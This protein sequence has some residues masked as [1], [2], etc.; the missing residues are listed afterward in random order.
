[1]RPGAS[2][3][4]GLTPPLASCRGG[5]EAPRRDLHLVSDP[6]GKPSR[7]QMVSA[8]SDR[9][10][11]RAGAGCPRPSLW[12][13]SSPPKIGPAFCRKPSKAAASDRHKA[14]ADSRSGPL[15]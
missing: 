12:F 14:S 9:S 1:M 13:F 2:V 8:A 15:M 7:A 3:A 10:D 6:T 4:P 5:F 11:V